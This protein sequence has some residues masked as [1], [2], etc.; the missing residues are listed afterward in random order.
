MLIERPPKYSV[1]QIMGFLK[2]KRS[3]KI[4][5]RHANLKYKYGSRSF[6]CRGHYG[7]TVGRNKKVIA[8]YKTDCF[9]GKLNSIGQ[10]ICRKLK[11]LLPETF[12]R[13]LNNCISQNGNKSFL[14]SAIM[15]WGRNV[16]YE[17]LLFK[18]VMRFKAKDFSARQKPQQGLSPAVVF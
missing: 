6:W 16:N 3:L 13:R 14:F 9:L 11:P 5:D 15:L 17:N 1:A 2:G 7:D 18:S 10:C 12:D 4:F 8:E